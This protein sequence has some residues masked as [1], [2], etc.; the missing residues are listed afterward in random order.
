MR[1]AALPRV[2]FLSCSLFAERGA[3]F[4]IIRSL[5]DF[6]SFLERRQ[7]GSQRLIRPRMHQ[8]Q[9]FVRL[10]PRSHLFDLRKT[11]R[12]INRVFRPGTPGAEKERGPPSRRGIH[13]PDESFAWRRQ[14]DG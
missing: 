6:D 2:Q 5:G 13:S 8:E 14:G 4:T 10:D 1:R 3:D 9:R 7:D 11:D 12:E